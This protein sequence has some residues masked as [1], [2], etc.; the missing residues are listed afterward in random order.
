MKLRTRFRLGRAA[1]PLEVGGNAVSI[2]HDGE[3]CFPAMLDAIEGAQEEVL[4]EMYWFHSDRIG[5][6]FA[7]ALM[8]AAQRGVVVRVIYD[9]V[10]SWEAEDAMFD[11]MRNAGCEVHMFNPI[12]PWRKR[13]NIG[14][15]NRRDHRKLLIVDGRTFFTGGV[16]I[17]DAWA[18][19]EEGGGGWR[20]DMVLVEGPAATQARAIFLHTW[21]A[22]GENPRHGDGW[23]PAAEPVPGADAPVRVLANF[24]RGDR[25]GI[26]REYLRR[27]RAARRFIYITNS[28]FVP[29][30]AVR[31]SLANAARR[32]VDVRVLLPGEGDVLAIHYA[33]RRLYDWLMRHGITL[34]EWQRTVLHSKSAVIDGIWSTVGTYNL[35]HRSWRFNLEVNVAVAD[36]GVGG[37]MKARFEQDL[38]HSMPVSRRDWRFRPLSER[39]VES[40]FYLFRKL[41]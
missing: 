36:P 14:V 39:M 28:Y 25:L 37:A 34:Y 32:G 10:G 23:R 13:F 12:A 19:V 6:R 15:V 9:A 40:F 11:A 38:E 22:L 41:L 33:S 35:D 31:R 4:L 2:L 1:A 8:E 29:D 7:N 26:R 20:D 3:E 5:M 18:P 24:Y 16:N 21:R 30:R 17:G 27:I